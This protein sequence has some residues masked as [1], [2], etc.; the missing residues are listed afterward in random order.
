MTTIRIATRKSPLAL[1]Q[2]EEVARQIKTHYPNINVE[3]VA[4]VSEGDQRLDSPLASF[5]G[6][7][8]FLKELEQ[9]LVAGQTDIAVHSMKDVPAQLPTGLE[10]V[11]VLERSDPSDALVSNDYASLDALPQGAIVGTSSTRRKSQLLRYRSDLHIQDIRGNLST[12]L[13]KLDAGQYQALILATAGLQR[14]GMAERIRQRLEH[15]VLLPAIGQGV[16]GIE[17]RADNLSC[18]SML[19]AIN[20]MPS[21]LCSLAERSCGA[22]LEADCHMPVAVHAS[23]NAEQQLQIKAMVSNLTG[24]QSI[25]DQISGSFTEAHALGQRLA[26]QLL[27][28]GATQILAQ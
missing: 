6:K 15:S 22:Q 27:K 24:T 9:S 12:R 21:W 5:G 25:F 28:Q 19:S 8:L 20:H 1:W 4:L 18:I 26:D 13:G 10:I 7:G 23:F 14:L 16:I 11:S 2:A 17:C 3:Y